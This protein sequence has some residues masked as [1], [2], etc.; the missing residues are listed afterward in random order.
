M[1]Y[2]FLY[3]QSFESNTMQWYLSWFYGHVFSGGNGQQTH[4]ISTPNRPHIDFPLVIY[5][6]YNLEH[7]IPKQLNSGGLISFHAYWR[8]KLRLRRHLRK[9]RNGWMNY[10]YEYYS[11]YAHYSIWFIYQKLSYGF[12]SLQYVAW[13]L[14]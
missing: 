8:L 11:K 10:K 3:F 14:N 4:S 6:F 1:V 9:Q 7:F 13:D 5:I 2:L 12:N